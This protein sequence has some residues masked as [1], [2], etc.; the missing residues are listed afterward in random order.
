MRTFLRVSAVFIALGVAGGA[1]AQTPIS[2]TIDGDEAHGAIALPGGI[3]ADLTI[4]FEHPTGLT[5][6]ALEASAQVVNP[7]DPALLSR[8]PAETSIPA[9]FPVLVHIGPSAGSS[10]TFRSVA[11]VSLHTY[12]LSYD[13]E[14]PCAL[15]KA[16]DGGPFVD[17]ITSEGSGSYRVIGGGGD[18]SE[19][20]I[21]R[22]ARGIDD[23]ILGK[24]DALQATL[25]AHAGSMPLLV[26]TTLQLRLSAARTLYLAGSLLPAINKLTN[27]AS[28]VVAHTGADIPGTWD[29]GDPSAINVAGLLRT[30]TSTLKFS[31]DRKASQ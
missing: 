11:S 21:V 2:L 9:A 14:E 4:T 29:A 19:F 22:D 27:F 31:L 25:T 28:Y 17:I 18:F 12:N 24:F 13:T 16:H 1:S 3:A 8:L 30:E 26:A 23:V 20:L 15:V 6:T 10:L 5:P 7:L